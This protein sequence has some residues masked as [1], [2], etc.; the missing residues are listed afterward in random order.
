MGE[1]VGSESV[2]VCSFLKLATSCSFEAD[3]LKY[4]K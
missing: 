3:D 1:G 4:C 2:R